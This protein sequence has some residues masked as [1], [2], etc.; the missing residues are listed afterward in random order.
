MAGN[1]DAQYLLR[2]AQAEKRLNLGEHH[3]C[4][5]IL[6]EVREQTETASDI[7]P[8]VYAAHAEVSAAY[9]RRKDD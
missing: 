7:D 8:K 1:R 4:M 6:N 2:I 5:Q 3:D 9:Y